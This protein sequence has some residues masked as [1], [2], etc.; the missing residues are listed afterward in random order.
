[1]ENLHLFCKR[2][3]FS[4]CYKTNC[5]VN[6]YSFYFWSLTRGWSK[7]FQ[8]HYCHDDNAKSM[9]K[10]FI[11]LQKFSV[12]CIFNSLVVFVT[13]FIG[14]HSVFKFVLLNKHNFI[15]KLTMSPIEWRANREL[16]DENLSVAYGN[17]WIDLFHNLI[18]SIIITE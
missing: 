9:V 14:F 7:A 1:M 4:Q 16:K 3:T 18:D 8:L 12:L 15:H 11:F 10:H 17:N 13:I 2:T 5:F 6:L